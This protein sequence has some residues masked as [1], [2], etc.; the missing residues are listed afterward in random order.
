MKRL[1][2]LAIV[3]LAASASA[4]AGPETFS[5]DDVPLVDRAKL[6]HYLQDPATFTLVDARTPEEYAAGHIDGAINVPVQ[7]WEATLDRLPADRATPIVVYCRVGRRAS[8]LMAALES[9]GYHTVEVLPKRQMSWT[10]DTQ[11]AIDPDGGL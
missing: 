3:L 10:G 4:W 11:P 2:H 5:P 1:Y 8:A 7:D 9:Q 6:E